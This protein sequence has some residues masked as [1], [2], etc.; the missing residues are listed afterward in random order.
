MAEHK[1]NE[2]I[3]E[4]GAGVELSGDEVDKLRHFFT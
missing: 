2:L 1:Q 3:S 4:E